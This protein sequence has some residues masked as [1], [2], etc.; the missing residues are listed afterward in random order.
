MYVRYAVVI[1]K[2]KRNYSAYVPDLP[3][4]MATEAT[5]EDVQKNI[6]EAIQFHLDGM[7]EDG[8]RPPR[9]TASCGYVFAQPAVN[10]KSRQPR[11]RAV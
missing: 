5:D 4:C 1:E 9:P 3:G 2:A 6:Y 10:G 7:R 8:I 11:R